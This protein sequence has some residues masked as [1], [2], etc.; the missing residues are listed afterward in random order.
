MSSDS[1]ARN[2]GRDGE[3]RSRAEVADGE[4]MKRRHIRKARVESGPL[5]GSDR[6]QRA[7]RSRGSAFRTQKV[8][9]RRRFI[10]AAGGST[11]VDIVDAFTAQWKAERPRLHIEPLAVWGRLKRSA[12]LFEKRLSEV[13]DECG[14]KMSEFEVLAALVRGGSPYEARPTELTR[15]LIITPGAVTA[16]LDNL[17]ARGFITARSHPPDRRVQ[18]VSLTAAGMD[19]F[20]PALER[21][22][23]ECEAM[24]SALRDNAHKQLA[25]SL[26]AL[27]AVLDVGRRTDNPPR[28]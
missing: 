19:A 24:L 6:D 21:V 26:R 28:L 11:A 12:D 7:S 13:L 17:K 16:R 4:T 27:M 9:R 3:V 20:E 18:L 23:R 10:D 5:D 15:S 25:S 14:L 22:T 1:R 8:P 2:H